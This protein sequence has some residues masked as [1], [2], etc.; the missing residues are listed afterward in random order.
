MKGTEKQIKWAKEIAR[1]EVVNNIIEHINTADYIEDEYREMIVAKFL[2]KKKDAKFWIDNRD[3]FK[4]HSSDFT[5]RE[6]FENK[7]KSVVEEVI[8]PLFG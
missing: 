8:A 5:E 7:S 4:G 2:E 6:G 3:Y 1:E